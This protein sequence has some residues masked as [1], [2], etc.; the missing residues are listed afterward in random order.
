MDVDRLNTWLHLVASVGV[1]AGLFFLVA[2]MNQSN[3]IASYA[4][5]HSRRNQ[6]IE[7]NTVRIENSDVYAKFQAGVSD[8]TPAEQANALMTARQL[9][10]SW[11]DAEAAY[12]HGLLSDETFETNLKDIAVTFGEA[13]GL[14]PYFA[15]LV[16]EYDMANESSS[17][18]QQLAEEVRKT[19]D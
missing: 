17:V 8:L 9:V 13:P 15:Y 18:S 1:I 2:E 11:K 10:N 19:R 14:I 4:A 7:L 5:E 12:N 16:K 3:R 6:W